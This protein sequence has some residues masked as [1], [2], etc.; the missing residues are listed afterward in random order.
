MYHGMIVIRKEPD[1][2]SSD[3]VAKLRGI[4]HMRKIGHTGTLDPAAE[5]VLPVCLG[6]G[7][8]LAE[9]IADR[10]KEYEAV[11]K[12]GVKTDTQDMTGTVLEE[13]SDDEVKARVSEA[14]IREVIR[15]FEGEID[16]I[17]PMYSAV[18]IDGKRLY[19]LARE[20]KTVERK[21][22][23]VR[24]AEI[25]VQKIN[26]PYVTLRVVCSKGTYIRTLC[27]DIGTKLGVGGAMEHLLRTRVGIFDLEKALTLS[28]LEEIM[29]TTPEKVLEYIYPI[30]SF[31]AESPA[32]HVNDASM[33]FLMNGNPLSFANTKEGDAGEAELWRGIKNAEKEH[34][35]SYIRVYGTEESGETA[36]YGLYRF[37]AKRRRMVCIKMFHKVMGDTRE[38]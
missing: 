24:I 31:F 33:P 32:V 4:L 37:D 8:K 13:I 10:D 12:L 34:P 15:S 28:Q 30:D 14:Q 7:T 27:E 22:R 9:L 3:V 36:F 38:D 2:T 18:W 29:H 21:P 19:E 23:R 35:G 11:L 5:G 6:N 25:E 17:P 16:Q 20:G 1:F 26:L